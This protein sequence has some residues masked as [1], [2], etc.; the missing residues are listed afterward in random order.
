MRKFFDYPLP[1]KD[2]WVALRRALQVLKAN[3][4]FITI[5]N[6]DRGP[7]EI[8]D[9]SRTNFST[10]SR[11]IEGTLDVYLNGKLQQEGMEYT[12]DAD[13]Q[14]YTFTFTPITGEQI[15]HRYSIDPAFI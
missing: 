5:D 12:V 9:G 11:F 14:G 10:E 15:Q 13:L 6:T 3:S 1:V 4:F 7:T 8:T 2:D